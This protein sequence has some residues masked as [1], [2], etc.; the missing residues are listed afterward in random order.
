MVWPKTSR[1][2]NSYYKDLHNNL[3]KFDFVLGNPPFNVD[4]VDKECLKGRLGL[5]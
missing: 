2:G 5:F 4:R 1:Q 3:S